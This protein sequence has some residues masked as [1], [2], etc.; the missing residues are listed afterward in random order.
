MFGN[1]THMYR[2]L[3]TQEAEYNKWI[4]K[5]EASL[6][7]NPEQRL[8]VIE[9]G[10]GMRVPSVRMEVDE[11]ITDILKLNPDAPSPQAALIRV[12]PEDTAL[13][14][15]IPVTKLRMG[16]LSALHAIDRELGC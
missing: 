14:R 15:S 3:Q 16:A 9:I 2:L 6:K 12:N 13:H 8:I 11:V 1:D 7:D 4:K 10:C 5:V